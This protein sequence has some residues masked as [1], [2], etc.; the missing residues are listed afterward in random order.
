[1][2]S[3]KI[4]TVSFTAD[5]LQPLV[6]GGRI[7]EFKPESAENWLNMVRLTCRHSED[8]SR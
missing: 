8:C 4:S 3:S 2:A 7:E 5:R 6:T 1:L